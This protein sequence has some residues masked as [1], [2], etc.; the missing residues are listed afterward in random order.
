VTK[1]IPVMGGHGAVGGAISN[2]L[3]QQQQQNPLGNA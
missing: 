1:N 2:L 3:H